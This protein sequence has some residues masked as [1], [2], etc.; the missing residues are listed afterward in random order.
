MKLSK[1]LT[2]VWFIGTLPLVFGLYYVFQIAS[3]EGG[4]EDPT[5]WQLGVAQTDKILIDN[6]LCSVR[7]HECLDKN[8]MY[9]SGTKEFY[10]IYIYGIN[11]QAILGQLSQIFIDDYK[12]L[13]SMKRLDIIAYSLTKSDEKKIPLLQRPFE[14]EIFNLSVRS[15]K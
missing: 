2:T 9:W 7:N 13:P 4:G 12:S 3:F 11:D 1:F 10:K 8:S 5:L 15:D 6:G 14:H